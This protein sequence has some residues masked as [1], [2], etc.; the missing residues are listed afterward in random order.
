VLYENITLTQKD[1]REFQLAAGAMRAGINIL[2]KQA[3]IEAENLKH[4]YIA[5]G[6][7]SFIRRSSAQRIGIIPQQVNHNK[8][9]YVGNA[10]LSGARGT[11]LSPG[12]RKITEEIA[13]KTK[14]VELSTSD[15]FQMEFAEAMI[16]PEP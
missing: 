11:I 6:F 13:T 2:L 10:S 9:Q 4:V 7:G 12:L 15:D 14:H 5:G 3:N 16:F 1:V 8:I